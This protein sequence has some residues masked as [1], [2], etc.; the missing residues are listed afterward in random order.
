MF[1]PAAGRAVRA[2]AQSAFSS[3]VLRASNS[4]FSTSPLDR[5]AAERLLLQSTIVSAQH[6]LARLYS[7]WLPASIAI[8]SENLSMAVAKSPAANA[9]LPISFNSLDCEAECV[10]ATGRTRRAT[11]HAC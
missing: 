4:A 10:A 7:T 11:N 5:Y 3:T 1:T 8:A 6:A 2:L 9:L